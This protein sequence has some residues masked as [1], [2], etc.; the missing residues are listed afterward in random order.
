MARRTT[1]SYWTYGERR[2]TQSVAALTV[3]IA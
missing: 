2:T 3:G 1:E